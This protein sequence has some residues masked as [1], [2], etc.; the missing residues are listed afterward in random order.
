MPFSSDAEP[1]ADIRLLSGISAL[2]ELP[3][4]QR[5]LDDARGLKT[6]GL[7][8]GYRGSPLGGY[9][10]QL[11]RAKARLKEAGVEFKPGLNEDLAATALWGAQMHS[12]FGETS[13]DGVFGIWYGKGPGVDR[14]G[15]VFRNA[16][17]MG[18]SR[19]GGVLAV[20]G[21]DHAAQS[22]M[23]PH[24]T[25]GIFQSVMMP[26]LQPSSVKEI[27][28]LGLAGIELS[29]YSGL[30][31]AFKTIAEIVE[32]SATIEFD[33]GVRQWQQPDRALPRH[34]LNWDPS[35]NWPAER[36]EL[37]RRQIDERLPAALDWIVTNRINRVEFKPSRPRIV[38]A[39]TGKA[40]Q[41]T[42]QALS[43]LGL[44]DSAL[45]R[46]GIGIFKYGCS[47]PISANEILDR[48]GRVE[49]ILVIEEKAPIIEDQLK[50]GMYGRADR[51]RITGKTDDQG[52]RLLRQTLEFTPLDIARALKRRLDSI[53]VTNDDVWQRSLVKLGELERASASLVLG[54]IAAR[55]PFFCSG[56]PHNTSTKTP[57]GSISGGGIG[58]HVMALSMPSRKTT[59]F[60]QMGG[61]GAQWIGA[62]SFSKTAHI[63]QNLGDGTYEHSGL[64]AIRAAVAARTNITYKI[65][66]NDAV[67]MTGGQPLDTETNPLNIVAQLRAEK[68]GEVVFVSDDPEKWRKGIKQIPG[69]KVHHRDELDAIQ[70][71]LREIEGVTAIVYEQTCAAEK[72][73]RRKRGTLA[74]PPKRAFINPRVCEGC[75]DC[76]VKSNCMS[77]EPLE[78]PLGRKRTI[79]QSSCNKD[80]SC[81]QGFCPSFVEIEAPVQRKPD[82]ALVAKAETDLL[83][84]LPE[85]A[86]NRLTS[87]QNFYVTGIGGLG[88]LT[89]GAL[90][91]KAAEL[92]GLSSTVLDFT[93]LA[94]KNGAVVSHVR[95]GPA[96]MPIHAV[97]IPDGM[98]DVLLAA[99]ALVAADVGNLLKLSPGRTAGVINTDEAPTASNVEDPDFQLPTEESLR[100]IAGRTRR[101]LSHSLGLTRLAEKV[102][103]NS[104][105]GN[106]MLLGYAW[107][108]GLVPIRR[109]AL[110]LAIDANGAAVG[111]NKRAFE[112]GRAAAHD[113]DSVQS[114]VDPDARKAPEDA[115]TAAR[116]AEELT[117]YQDVAYADRYLALVGE[118]SQAGARLGPVADEFVRLVEKNAYRVMA[119]KDE[120]E[121]ARLYASD[122]YKQAL[123]T[124]FSDWKSVHVW[125]APP[126]LTL[127]GPSRNIPEKRKFGSWVFSVFSVLERMKRLRGTVF[128]P[129]G[130]TDERRSERKLRDDYLTMIGEVASKLTI[131]NI[132]LAEQLAALPEGI[133]GFGH[134]KD[135]AMHAAHQ[136]WTVLQRQFEL[137]QVAA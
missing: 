105:A 60:S 40:H 127:F 63:F 49:E 132:S 12:A 29:R 16:N 7:I 4:L 44:N 77:V 58:C 106:I 134:V 50:S 33:Q 121:V 93:G 131:E 128:D 99:D 119:Y 25:D 79:N 104:I 67:A 95:I 54:Q 130:F 85:P 24:Q 15:D 13:V 87:I 72:R 26:V 65:L 66:F 19:L 62:D 28:E 18:A 94:Q 59:T 10:Q 61:E 75:G 115:W 100:R 83:A 133:R 135:K 78:T 64:L 3:V 137:S 123:A 70:L 21:D 80:F 42:L 91:G 98:T 51:P 35:I 6:A 1:Q 30:W 120:Y 110:L 103:G 125:L 126:T 11:W 52:K 34:G 23:F 56:C 124:Q 20:G 17:V 47:W 118:V 101:E 136:R 109:E 116:Y 8:S 129:F 14:S 108:K 111:M 81:T 96:S 114:I 43:D 57:D 107:Q 113:L 36:S 2:V 31:V 84:K 71:R 32:S 38:L 86:F 90:L 68:V 88:V 102:F 112:W 53:G 74:D 41:D 39:T 45:E 69:A 55:K 22:S 92:D 9:D 117:A 37:E 48:F 82:T 97:R 5:K 73:R 89:L 27:I 122:D 76:S 46:L